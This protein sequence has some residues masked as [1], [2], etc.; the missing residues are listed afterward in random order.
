MII[1]EIRAWHKTAL[2]QMTAP[3]I[4]TIACC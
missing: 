2:K 4:S 1:N 3:Q